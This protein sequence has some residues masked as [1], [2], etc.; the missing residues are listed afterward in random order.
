MSFHS[1]FQRGNS[2]VVKGTL[3]VQKNSQSVLTIKDRFFYVAHDSAKS[4]VTRVIFPE[5]ML[6]VMHWRGYE[7]GLF[8]FPQHEL[9]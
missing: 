8:S 6:I 1:R 2:N 4:Y 9:F 7:A 5:S 3:D